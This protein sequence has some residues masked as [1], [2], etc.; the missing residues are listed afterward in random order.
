MYRYTGS[1]L[2]PPL[3]MQARPL[4]QTG[5]WTHVDHMVVYLRAKDIG[6]MHGRPASKTKVSE[7]FRL[8]MYLDLY[9]A[10]CPVL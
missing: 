5:A 8:S 3:A 10:L 1:F 7:P 2:V 4:S 9:N 6:P